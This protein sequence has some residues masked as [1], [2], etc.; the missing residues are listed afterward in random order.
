MR[1][2]AVV[3]WR[4]RKQAHPLH[5]KSAGAQ[6]RTIIPPD[7]SQTGYAICTSPRS[8]SNFLCQVLASTDELG[9]P[10]EYFNAPGRR[11][12]GLPDYP[13]NIDEQIQWILTKSIT[14]NRIYALKLFAYQHD[15]ISQQV[16]WTQALPNLQFVFLTRRDLLA[17][18]ISWAMAIQT[19]QYRWS[20]PRKSEPHYDAALISRCLHD[21]AKEQARWQMFFA[22]NDIHPA[23]LVYEDFADRPQVA[24]ECVSNLLRM[25]NVPDINSTRVDIK[26]QRNAVNLEWRRRFVAQE[27]D[28]D[29][30]DPL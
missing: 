19:E 21:I 4:K 23:T 27:G 10:L 30:I 8:G 22:R 1:H 15:M 25:T 17:Q 9:N 2:Q 16:S 20:Q 29:Y 11:Q 3:F 7:P 12:L 13:D 24:V 26:V 14:P 28:R 5:I 18:A 6:R